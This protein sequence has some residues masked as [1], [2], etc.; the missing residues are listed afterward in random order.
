MI[1][2]MQFRSEQKKDM[3]ANVQPSSCTVPTLLSSAPNRV[4]QAEVKS[5]QVLEIRG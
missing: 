1:T 4:I 5:H 2:F 3:F